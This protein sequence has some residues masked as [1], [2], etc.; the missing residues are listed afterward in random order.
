MEQFIF[1]KTWVFV[2]VLLWSFPW[3]G[4]ALW[5]SARRGHLGWFVALLVLNTLAIL[6]ILYIFIFSK[7][8]RKK[9]SSR[10][11]EESKH[12]DQSHSNINPMIV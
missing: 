6:D 3:K 10:S 5:M 9:F 7:W 11:G 2:L 8:K 1:E 12:E 4:V